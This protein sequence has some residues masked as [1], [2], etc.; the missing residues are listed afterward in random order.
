MFPPHLHK[1]AV[2]RQGFVEELDISIVGCLTPTY[3]K[4]NIDDVKILTLQICLIN[5]DVE[6]FLSLNIV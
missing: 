2:I 3:N 6:V 5:V 4:H 1:S